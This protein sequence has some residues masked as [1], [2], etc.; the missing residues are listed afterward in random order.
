[1]PVSKEEYE[2]LVDRKAKGEKFSAEWLE[3]ITLR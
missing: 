1:M 2:A 3:D